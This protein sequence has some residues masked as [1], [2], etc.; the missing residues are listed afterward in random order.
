MALNNRDRIGR[1]IELLPDGLL[2]LIERE[3]ARRQGETW[4]DDAVA[5]AREGGFSLTSKQ[6]P[7]FL[8]QTMLRNWAS[9]FR[10]VLPAAARNYVGELNDTRNKWAH[11]EPFNSD[12]TGRAL[13]TAERLLTA[14]G[15]HKDLIEQ[16]R[17]S[18]LEHQRAVIEAETK[19]ATREAA[20]APAVAAEGLKPWRSV[21][22]PHEDVARGDFNASEFAANLAQVAQGEGA[23][24]YTDP[25]EFFQRTYLTEGLRE[26]LGKSMRRI[27]GDD[28]APP[29]FN[30]QTNFGGGKTHSMLALYHLFGD[31]RAHRRHCH[32]P[33]KGAGATRGLGRHSHQPRPARG[34]ARRHSGEHAVGRAGLAARR[35]HG[36]RRRRR[37]RPH[38]HQPGRGP[39]GPYRRLRPVPDPHRRVGRLCAT[40]LRR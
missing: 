31:A 12:D 9:Y 19:R 34:Q 38:R 36:V 26:L 33:A 25:V 6:D 22:T 21:L 5:T 28:N 18:R 13:D 30:L 32:R 39:P 29:T 15:A 24:E 40:A 27:S 4:F 2:P 16:V 14:V 20:A 35:P 1:M 17:R 8:L 7:Q 37:G 23:P 3:M 11:N 10:H